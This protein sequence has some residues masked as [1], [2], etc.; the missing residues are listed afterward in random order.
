MGESNRENMRKFWPHRHN[1]IDVCIMYKST[2]LIQKKQG[3]IKT[4]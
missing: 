4:I 1:T 2:N 3:K